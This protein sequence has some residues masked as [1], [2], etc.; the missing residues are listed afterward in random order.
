M[1]G[2]AW[3]WAG[4]QFDAASECPGVVQKELGILKPSQT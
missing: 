1:L 2:A 3:T 4:R